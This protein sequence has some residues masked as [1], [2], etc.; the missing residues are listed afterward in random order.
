MAF[1]LD[2]CCL[3]FLTVFV[4]AL[5]TI[6]PSINFSNSTFSLGPTEVAFFATSS[7]SYSGSHAQTKY[8]GPLTSSPPW[9]DGPPKGPGSP[10]PEHHRPYVPPTPCS[11]SVST[12][13]S[14]LAVFGPGTI[15]SSISGQPPSS[16]YS[17][18]TS[19]SYGNSGAYGN[20]AMGNPDFNCQN[21]E[22][23]SDCDVDLCDM[24]PLNTNPDVANVY[25]IME[26]LDRFHTCFTGL[27]Q[28]F[29]VSAIATALSKDDWAETFYVDKEV[30]SI[31]ALRL[32]FAFLQIIIGIGAA[33]AGM[34]LAVGDAIASGGIA[35]FGGATNAAIAAI[36]T[37]SAYTKDLHY[38]RW[39]ES[40]SGPAN[41]S[42][43][44]D[45][46]A[47]YLYWW[48]VVPEQAEHT[49]AGQ[50]L[51]T[52]KKRQ[53]DDVVL[54]T[55]LRGLAGDYASVIVQDIV[56]SSLGAYEI[57]GYDYD[58]MTAYSRVKSALEG[59]W[60]NP[61]AQGPRWE[62]TF[63]IPVCNVQHGDKCLPL[64]R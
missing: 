35:L 61:G 22:S 21:D 57:A 41:Y 30:K 34:G 1:L 37:H 19:G 47:W 14:S 13:A 4:R 44:V 59:Q 56:L 33:L 15:L 28:A 7:G 60:A 26:S 58:N 63:T 6:L 43:S 11:S 12:Q 18:A 46:V 54:V 38:G 8:G 3:V 42:V 51:P 27:S 25:Y 2:I 50:T 23:S 16:S 40:I 32:V 62:G 17:R 49:F 20:R 36:A 10:P 53:E 5:P 45:D 29:E 64:S 52:Q 48:S 39:C 55:G 9:I 31:T 24:I